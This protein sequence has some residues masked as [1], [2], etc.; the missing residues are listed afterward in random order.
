M[1]KYGRV[2]G[3]CRFLVPDPDLSGMQRSIQFLLAIL[4]SSG[5]QA[6]HTDTLRFHSAAFDAEREVVVHLPEFHRYAAPEVRMPVI[7]LLDGQHDWLVGPLLNDIRYLQYTH[8]V[9]QA[10]VVTVP[11]VDR[12]RECATDS[13][14]QPSMPL[15][16]MLT[17]ELPTLLAP[18]HPSDIQVLVGHSFSS[19]F[20]LY[21]YL[22][23]P[24]VFNAVIA[25]SPLH[26]VKEAMPRVAELLEVRPNDRVLVAVG[27]PQRLKD[28][29][30][31]ERL[32]PVMERLGKDPGH[33]RLL[34][35][36]Y[37]SA[38]H[39]S[40]PV[41][42][43]P[44]LLSTLFLP[45]SVRD[46]LVPVNDEYK[47]VTPAPPAQDLL[48]MAE[49]S[50]RFLGG[51]LPWEVAEINGIASRL[52]SSDELEQTIAVYRKG[53]ELYPKL[54]EFHWALGELLLDTDPQRAHASLRTALELLD[55]EERELP[56]RMEIRGEIEG[57]MR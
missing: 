55:T 17:A 48:R 22:Q 28:G 43:F 5:I 29:G 47:L 30:H 40:L 14:D 32:A 4:G 15:L 31:A 54:Y 9:P 45:F 53:I 7:I 11:H 8:E 19:S 33:G 27:G 21:A 26:Q 52:W 2:G 49:A 37:P 57:L 6:Q 41:I 13:V 42:A 18:Y 56:E 16:R 25:L 34:Y 3:R 46:S 1:Q 38:G 24:D 12:V 44:E 39:T 20:A 50:N 10:I 35:R 23:A 51:S 36:D